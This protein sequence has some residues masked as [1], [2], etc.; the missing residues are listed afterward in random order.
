LLTFCSGISVRVPKGSS[1]ESRAAL[2]RSNLGLRESLF[3]LKYLDYDNGTDSET[4]SADSYNSSDE[5]A[6]SASEVDVPDGDVDGGETLFC[7]PEPQPGDPHARSIRPAQ[8]SSASTNGQFMAEQE[9]LLA[10]AKRPGALRRVMKSRQNARLRD[11]AGLSMPATPRN[12]ESTAR[13]SS[14]PGARKV[15]ANG[16]A[17]FSHFDR[18]SSMSAPRSEELP[19]LAGS[20]D[21]Q[22]FGGDGDSWDDMST[23]T[24][25]FDPAKDGH[26]TKAK[27][28][29]TARL[30]AK[31]NL[32]PASETTST[33]SRPV[34]Q[35][36]ETGEQRSVLAPTSNSFSTDGSRTPV[37]T[38]SKKRAS[39][40]PPMHERPSRRSLTF[41][42]FDSMYDLTPPAARRAL[43]EHLRLG[44]HS[45]RVKEEE[46]KR[47]FT[48][49]G[50]VAH[51]PCINPTNFTIRSGR[52]LVTVYSNEADDSRKMTLGQAEFIIS[53]CTCHWADGFT[54]VWT[55]AQGK[56]GDMSKAEV[57]LAY[58]EDNLWRAARA[59]CPP[60]P[61][62]VECI[63]IDD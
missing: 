1:R 28:S 23:I 34:L 18:S 35:S 2:N 54:E 50:C 43:P 12:P 60:R 51:R 42:S 47:E 63:I 21:T 58:F 17:P 4:Y 31:A 36:I 22:D 30:A 55:D 26:S 9:S 62:H 13:F 44:H 46:G 33:P 59:C 8:A 24:E 16:R 37:G 41:S 6:D 20:D 27:A 3:R 45:P 11:T 57:L 5:S 40:Q 19:L 38:M 15:T 14:P 29:R 48:H 39:S 25:N 10:R 32:S 61:G 53:H 7:T 56:F 52:P 49:P